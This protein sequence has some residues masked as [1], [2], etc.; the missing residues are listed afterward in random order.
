MSYPH[1]ITSLHFKQGDRKKISKDLFF[2]EIS[3]AYAMGAMNLIDEIVAKYKNDTLT[4]DE[5]IGELEILTIQKYDQCKKNFGLFK[6]P[7]VTI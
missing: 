6:L 5:L 4:K 1:K 7:R 2:K 3:G